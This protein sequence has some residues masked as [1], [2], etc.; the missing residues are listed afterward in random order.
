MGLVSRL[1]LLAISAPGLADDSFSVKS[2]CC[3]AITLDSGGMGDFYQGERLGQF[4]RSG[5]SSSGRSIYQQ[6]SGSNFLYYL[7]SQAIW[8]VGPNVGQD[9][10]GVL[11]R[12]AGTCPENLSRDWEYYSD[13]MDSW[14]EDWTMEATCGNNGPTPDPDAEACT[15]GQYCDGCAIWSEAN[16]VRYCCANNCDSGSLDVST[17]NGE[18]V[19]TCHH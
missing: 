8:M 11:N 1:I 14:E 9:F 15:W 5:S 18:V 3:D 19:C 16:G 13:F 4:V 6:S 2:S 10:G 12:E 17:S 7:S